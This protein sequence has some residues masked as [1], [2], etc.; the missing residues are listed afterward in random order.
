MYH[1][2]WGPGSWVG[3]ATELRAGRSGNRIPVGR[4]FSARPDMPWGPP[5][6]LY[7]GYRVFSEGNVRPGRAADHSPPSSAVV[8]D[9]YSYNSTHPLGHNRACNGNALPLPPGLTFNNCTL[10]PHN[11]FVCFV[12]IWEQTAINTLYSI[13]WLV[14]ITET[15]CVYCAV[16][17]GSLNITYFNF[18]VWRASELSEAHSDKCCV[19]RKALMPEYTNTSIFRRVRNNAKSDY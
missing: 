7:N 6:L 15:E 2:V 8:M 18:S 10:C 17:T 3:I 16:R 9:D 4:N 11:V 1:Y 5:S 13:N 19:K 12:W 14:F